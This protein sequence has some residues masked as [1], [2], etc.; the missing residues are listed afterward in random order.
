MECVTGYSPPKIE[1]MQFGADVPAPLTDSLAI[2]GESNMIMP[3]DTGTV[4]AF[5]GIQ[6]YPS[7]NAFRARRGQRSPLMTPASPVSFA[8]DLLQS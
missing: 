5:L 4:D 2:Y 7:G 8:V 1:V 6:W 3:S